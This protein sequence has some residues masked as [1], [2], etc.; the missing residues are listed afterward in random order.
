MNPQHTI[1]SIDKSNGEVI[2]NANEKSVEG[3]FEIKKN[4]TFAVELAKNQN[5][6][7][8]Q[9]NNLQQI[10]EKDLEKRKA[11]K[12]A[13]DYKKNQ[14]LKR[15]E[16]FFNPKKP[17][18]SIEM[19][20]LHEKASRVYKE[21]LNKQ[22]ENKAED[23]DPENICPCC[24]QIALGDEYLISMIGNYEDLAH[25]GPAYPLYFQFMIYSIGFLF[26]TLL[27]SGIYN[28]VQNDQGQQCQ[29]TEQ[30]RV[31]FATKLAQSNR[32]Q[33]DPDATQSYLNLATCIVLIFYITIFRLKQVNF[34]RQ[35]DSYDVS[36]SDYTIF[37]DKIPLNKKRKDIQ[38]FI[39]SQVPGVKVMKIV[40]A[41]KLK[42]YNKW[43][44]ELGGDISLE[45]QDQIRQKI[46]DYENKCFQEIDIEQTF[47]GAAFVSFETEDQAIKVYEHF[48]SHPFIRHTKLYDKKKKFDNNILSVNRAPEPGDIN[49][50]NIEI[51]SL[52]KILRRS[53][54]IIVSAG[55]IGCCYVIIFYI[56]ESQDNFKRK[57]KNNSLIEAYAMLTSLSVL[58]IN[59]LLQLTIAQLANYE[60]FNSK[61]R[62]IIS[63]AKKS[64]LVQFINTTIVQFFVNL[65]QNIRDVW[66]YGGLVY[67]ITILLIYNIGLPSIIQGL[68]I[69]QIIKWMQQKLFF[70]K[71]E[72]EKARLTQ[73]QVHDIF[74]RA[75]FDIAPPFASAVNTLLLTCF[76][77]QLIPLGLVFSIISLILQMFTN[78]YL[79]VRRLSMPVPYGAEL[80]LEMNDLY[81]EII[82]LFFSLG[83][84]IFEYILNSEISSAAIAQLTISS[85]YFIFPINKYINK[86]FNQDLNFVESLSYSDAKV[87]GHFSTDYDRKNPILK[88][89]A[90]K[91][92][93]DFSIDNEK[94]P[95]KKEF[96][97]NL[98]YPD[99]QK[100]Q[101]KSKEPL[102]FVGK[103][104]EK[105]FEDN[106]KKSTTKIQKLK[107]LRIKEQ[108]SR[109]SVF[110]NQQIAQEEINEINEIAQ[111][112]NQQETSQQPKQQDSFYNI[113]QEETLRQE[114]QL[115]IKQQNQLLTQKDSL[116]S[117]QQESQNLILK[118]N[119][120][121]PIYDECNNDIKEDNQ[122]ILQS[123][124]LQNNLKESEQ[125]I[126]K[127][128]DLKSQS[129]KHQDG[130]IEK[131]LPP[132]KLKGRDLNKV[133]PI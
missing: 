128:P 110:Q 20:Y 109:Q 106:Y 75:Q 6:N 82:I 64:G 22:F 41:F 32:Q 47:A 3:H 88:T 76:Y 81:L 48:K 93:V 31:S 131:N 50:E 80:P 132:I 111:N 35:V 52:S 129:D 5:D 43:N 11:T 44:E 107:S 86:V 12:S 33:N 130:N 39:Y 28:M 53:V 46:Q 65:F 74:E 55:L 105:F 95:Q 10:D 59:Q 126:Q 56:Q 98:F 117:P 90:I 115:Q 121:Q 103:F 4:A 122:Q 9:E 42:Q 85:V 100:R 62:T 104:T 108:Q 17:F 99:V 101:S 68:Q 112:Q 30:C 133:V 51:S 49:W 21:V 72:K 63:V 26:I 7:E 66:V 8:D 36:V 60:S 37:F 18:F 57:E 94:D 89:E 67:D 24:S 78:K 54:S 79:L 15:K 16:T 34:A 102:S 127:Q 123:T 13:P 116:I 96:L 29:E 14:S 38:E 83:C 19:A 70:K 114:G 84:F 113:Q 25:L 119:Q 71:T 23:I 1:G 2:V 27:I 87:Q 124:I 125:L 40:Q 69:S 118:S 45:Q 73:I 91:K 120:Q 61:T 77:A 97:K 58:L 92:Y